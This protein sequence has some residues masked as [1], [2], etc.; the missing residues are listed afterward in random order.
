MLVLPFWI[1]ASVI[2]GYVY[3]AFLLLWGWAAFHIFK[4]IW[5]SWPIFLLADG[6]FLTHFKE[7]F[8]LE[9]LPFVKWV[10]VSPAA[11]YLFIFYLCSW[12]IYYYYYYCYFWLC[13]TFWFWCGWISQSLILQPSLC[14]L[15]H[16]PPVTFMLSFS[17]PFQMFRP[18]ICLKFILA[19]GEGCGFDIFPP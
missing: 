15:L 7:R 12:F 14:F 6:H 1:F 16:F 18:L 11:F 4:G 8:V 13:W 10:A 19:Y 5:Y 9:I 3:F 2:S 17:F